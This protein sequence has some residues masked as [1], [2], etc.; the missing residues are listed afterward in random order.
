MLLGLDLASQGLSFLLGDR[1]FVVLAQSLD[2][3]L[4]VSQV[5]LR[6]DE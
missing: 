4:V 6:A 3:R 2:A 1:V 5:L